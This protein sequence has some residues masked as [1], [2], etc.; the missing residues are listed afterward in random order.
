MIY[1]L[2]K[3]GVV[4]NTILADKAFVDAHYPGF[5]AV[6]IQNVVGGPG[7]GH[8]YDGSKFSPPDAV[9]VPPPEETRDQKQDRILS[10][11]VSSVQD[12]KDDL[13]AA[14]AE[15]EQAKTELATAKENVQAIADKVGVVVKEPDAPAPVDPPPVVGG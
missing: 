12:T 10:E 13:D 6:E 2:I 15:L 11:L 8:K 4:V 3:D 1:A 5:T 14:R 7:V 9:A